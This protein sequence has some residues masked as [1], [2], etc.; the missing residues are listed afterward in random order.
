LAII[1]GLISSLFLT[2]IIVPDREIMEKLI[3]NQKK[4]VDYEAEMIA[5]YDHRELSED[6]LLQN[7]VRIQIKDD[8]FISLRS[9]FFLNVITLKPLTVKIQFH[10][11][12]G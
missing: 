1:G 9:R 6:G 8:L 2:L 12:R 11:I 7:I 4:K 5:D 3:Q 10:S